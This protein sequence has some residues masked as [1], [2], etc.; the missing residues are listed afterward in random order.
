MAIVMCTQLDLGL[1]S[2]QVIQIFPFFVFGPHY[3]FSWALIAELN[4]NYP[5]KK[6]SPT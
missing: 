1:N 5:I 6:N 3:T 4:V 2:K